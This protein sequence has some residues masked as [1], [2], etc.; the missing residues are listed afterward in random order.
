VNV[1]CFQVEFSATGRS[2]VQRNPANRGVS[3]YECEASI[4]RRPWPTRG[5]RVI[6]INSIM[7]T[8]YLS[9]GKP[10]DWKKQFS[11]LHV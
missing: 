2:L 6:K 7:T 11:V 1:V 10:N 3:E 4:M 9:R 8:G 5:C